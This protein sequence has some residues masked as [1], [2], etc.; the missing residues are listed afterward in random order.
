MMH[1]DEEAKSSKILEILIRSSK[2]N[3]K[4]SSIVTKISGIMDKLVRK[5]SS[6]LDGEKVKLTDVTFSEA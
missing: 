5:A 3:Y 1:V 6:L 4:Y 2:M